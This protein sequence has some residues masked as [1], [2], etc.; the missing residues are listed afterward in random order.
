MSAPGTDTKKQPAATPAPE[1]SSAPEVSA[2]LVT[3]KAST[4]SSTETPVNN[5]TQ[6]AD[7]VVAA[8][9]NVGQVEATSMDTSPISKEI[10]NDLSSSF[11]KFAAS[12][13]TESTQKAQD[14]VDQLHRHYTSV[15]DKRSRTWENER[16]G[17]IRTQKSALDK[18]EE[19]NKS[20]KMQL[21]KLRD[22]RKQEDDMMTRDM[23]KNL[24][25]VLKSIQ[26]LTP[27]AQQQMEESKD[28]ITSDDDVIKFVRQYSPY[29]NKAASMVSEI[30]NNSLS[31]FG[32]SNKIKEQQVPKSHSKA[33][34]QE[35]LSAPDD[36]AGLV[37]P[38][39]SAKAALPGVNQSKGNPTKKQRV[40]GPNSYVQKY[41]NTNGLN[42][43]F[44]I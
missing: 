12:V 33:S 26:V 25:N 39:M 42:L 43:P 3:K 10:P 31:L 27:E 34:T 41:L 36:L 22:A 18:L 24:V 37:N 23:C 19:E 20:T 29:V 8:P 11:I 9:A 35:E 40:K 2:N 7:Q 13:P 6:N 32:T 28:I 14:L 15:L 17:I 1:V 30:S 44:E 38:K 16:Q 5:K 4:S 21:K